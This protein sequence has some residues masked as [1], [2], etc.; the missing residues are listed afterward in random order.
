MGPRNVFNRFW[1]KESLYLNRSKEPICEIESDQ[2]AM[3][4]N[5][6]LNQVQG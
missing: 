2:T 3:R 5:F 6:R 1:Q 4:T